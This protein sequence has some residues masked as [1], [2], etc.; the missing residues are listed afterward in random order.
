LEQEKHRCITPP[1]LTF[2]SNHYLY[3]KIDC[4]LGL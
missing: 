1:S 3:V 2:I 4:A